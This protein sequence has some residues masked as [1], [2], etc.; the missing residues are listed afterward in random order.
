M[1]TE[2]LL[3]PG[4]TH[5]KLLAT[6]YTQTWPLIEDLKESRF[7]GY[8]MLEF[9]EYEGCIIFDTGNIIQAFQ[10]EKNDVKSGID[11]LSGIYHKFKEKDGTI[12]TFQIDSEFVPFQFARYQTK[13]LKEFESKK[14]EELTNFIKNISK[15]IDF[16]C[17]NIVY[18][19]EEAWATVLLN[20]GQIVGS[21]LK[22]KAGKTVYETNE[23][24]L[25]E[26]IIKLAGTIKT[27][28]QLLGC[29]AIQ[30]Y[31]HSSQYTEFFDLLKKSETI[32]SVNNFL[33]DVLTSVI[34][35]KEIENIF[36]TAWEESCKKNKA[37]N[38]KILSDGIIGLEQINSKQF[39]RIIRDFLVKLQPKF[40]KTIKGKLA[41]KDMLSALNNQ[42]TGK[43]KE[44]L[45]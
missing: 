32:I 34:N 9:W 41:M 33:K 21:A 35:K 10:V 24:K 40:D 8:L 28:S 29:D 22:S 16:G 19:K 43:L 12:S 11:A 5:H 6:H 44:L 18:G 27:S 13:V 42:Y 39:Y 38:L 37:K 26:N 1:K 7:S 17:I 4:K 14:S 2:T 3:A 23:L 25:Y 15:E 36:N 45:I 20:N 30:S 31:R